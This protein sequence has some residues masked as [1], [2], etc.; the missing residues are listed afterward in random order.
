MRICTIVDELQ[1]NDILNVNNI[2]SLLGGLSQNSFFEKFWE[3]S[4]F[5]LKRDTPNFYQSVL[6]M[7]QMGDILSAKRLLSN[8]LRI[9]KNGKKI[10]FNMFSKANLEADKSAVLNEFRAGATLVFENIARHHLPLAMLLVKLENEYHVNMRANAYLTPQGSRGFND[11]YDTQDVFILQIVG[12]KTWRISNN[13]IKLPTDSTFASAR[14]DMVDQAKLLEVRTLQPGDLLYLPR[15]FVHSASACNTCSLHITISMRGKTGVDLI[16]KS[17]KKVLENNIEMRR[18]INF[19]KA[20]SGEKFKKEVLKAMDELDFDA[21][22]VELHQDYL[23]NTFPVAFG[24]LEQVFDGVT[25]GLNYILNINKYMVWQ[26]FRVDKEAILIF[27][28]KTMKFPEIAIPALEYISQQDVFRPQDL[29]NLDDSSKLNL[30][31]SLFNRGFII[32]SS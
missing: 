24:L 21:I 18:Y 15:G 9:Y 20:F 1:D 7:E 27:D 11:H 17:L 5:Y 13:P 32:S 29:P 23:T 10:P 16:H 12:G 2:D 22:A 25:L 19:K 6:D 30:C 14:Q 28:G 4:P 3:E 8:D 31:Q 26:Y